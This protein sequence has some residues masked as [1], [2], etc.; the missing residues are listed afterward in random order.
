MSSSPIPSLHGR[1]PF[2][3]RQKMQVNPLF[4]LNQNSQEYG[5]F[6]YYPLVIINVFLVNLPEAIQHILQLNH[7]N[8]SK[9]TFQYI[10]LRSSPGEGWLNRARHP[11]SL[12]T[13]NL[14]K[15]NREFKSALNNL[16][17]AVIG[18]INQRRESGM[19]GGSSEE[20]REELLDRFLDAHDEQTEVGKTGQQLHNDYYFNK[21]L[22]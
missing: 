7:Y 9:D 12:P 3:G 16:E 5:D 4:L 11:I 1:T 15:R 17:K 20:D 2:K 8:Y 6:I 14:S 21:E 13:S 10:L 22:D 19:Q 18:I